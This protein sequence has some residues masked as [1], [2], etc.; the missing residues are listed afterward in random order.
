MLDLINTPPHKIVFL[1]PGCSIATKPIA[2]A[3]SYWQAV[4]VSVRNKSN[5]IIS[6][7]MKNNKQIKQ[8]IKTMKQVSCRKKK[9]TT[10]TTTT[11]KKQSKHN[12]QESVCFFAFYW[13]ASIS[14][15]QHAV[16]FLSMVKLQISSL[17]SEDRHVSDN[18][19][20]TSP[21][22]RRLKVS[23]GQFAW[24]RLSL[25]DTFFE[26]WD[27]ITF[28]FVFRLGTALLHHRYQIKRSIPFISEQVLQK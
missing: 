25:P 8:T 10:T 3:A 15:R 22:G 27:V 14:R 21:G 12:K 7:K 23:R 20:R 2:E 28:L 19:I 1:G 9:T 4:Q 17:M 6:K 16:F 24:F 18:L 11:T 13:R 26:T 5:K